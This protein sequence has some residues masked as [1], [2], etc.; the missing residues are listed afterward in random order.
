MRIVIV[1]AGVGGLVAAAGLQADGHDVALYERRDDPGGLGAGL[2]LFG[3]SFAALDAV[4]LGEA[5]R[6][7]SSDAVSRLRT[8]QR[9]PSGR[10]LVSLP[11]AAAP[12]IRTLHRPV[13]HRTLAERLEPEVLR[14]GVDAQVAADGSPII[15]TPDR[16]ERFDLVVAADGLR[17]DA[18]RRWGLDRGVRYAG[19][20]AWR[21]VADHVDLTAGVGETW[22]RGQRFGI[23]PLAD[24]RA[25]W[26]AVQSTPAG[27]RPGD[28]RL[29]LREIF[30]GWHSPVPECVEATPTEALLRHDIYDLAR[31]PASFAAG[32]GLLLGDAAHAMT[33]DLGQ[34][35]G[36]AIE[37][38][39]TL[40]LL[41]RD[42]PMSGLAA[43]LARYDRIRR[44]R[45]R[46]FWR[47]S[48]LMGRLAQFSDPVS[49]GI[50]DAAI[51][52][53]PASLVS[54]AAETFGRWDPPR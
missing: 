40:V 48:R 17:S 52:V 50:R 18:R 36:Q 16:E 9:R 31:F 10:W 54:R 32:R 20:T 29:T 2:T 46:R 37:D 4:G 42:V 11:P 53:T 13:L 27:T 8:G 38:A 41:L 25:Y 14:L 51:R 44:S 19:Y 28:D 35:A 45:T 33:P 34:G 22:G 3:N 26:F 1:G 23:V 43:A 6:R 15:R 49:V 5:V 24:D 21:G 12:A 47:R 7:I 30:G 39:A